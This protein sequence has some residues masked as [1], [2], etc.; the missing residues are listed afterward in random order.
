M[1]V[2]KKLRQVYS[3][4]FKRQMVSD[5]EA[6]GISYQELGNKYNFNSSNLQR[7]RSELSVAKVAKKRDIVGES[8][9]I[10]DEVEDQEKLAMRRRIRELER[11]VSDKEIDLY[12]YGLLEETYKEACDAK[13]VAEVERRVAKK[14]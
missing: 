14:L 8:P 9:K 5:Y 11:I 3:E 7:W 4:S 12:L 2:K 10:I 6:G 13:V 1:L